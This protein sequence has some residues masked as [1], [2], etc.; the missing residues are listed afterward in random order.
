MALIEFK[1]VVKKFGGAKVLDDISFCV[2]QGEVLCIVGTSGVG[3]SVLL[4]HIV[5]LLS[6]TSGD[7]LVDGTN[8]VTCDDQTLYKVRSRMGYLFQSGALLA[9][10]T[11]AE[12]VSL[13][14]EECTDLSDDEI[15]KRVVAALKEVGLD[16]SAHK[17]PAEISGG[18]QKRA[19]L[20]RAIVRQADIVLYDEPTSGLDPV[21]SANINS[22]IKRLAK[23]RGI[24]SIVVTHDLPG[25]LGM[26]DRIML[27]SNARI[28]FCGTPSEF[29]KTDLDQA[30]AFIAA[31]KGIVL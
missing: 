20:A 7:V 22:L 25:A 21:T 6:P 2:D 28:V 26:A 11:V 15:S 8:V 18:M 10:K 1:N 30:K 13:P 14:L 3:K 17:Y 12:N 16:S 4:K 9:W 23:T 29:L 19:G 27:L 31:S 5:R 24:T